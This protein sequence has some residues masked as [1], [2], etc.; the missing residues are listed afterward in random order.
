[1][2]TWYEIFETDDEDIYEVYSVNDETD[3]GEP[4]F[5]GSKI[6]CEEWIHNRGQL[7]IYYNTDD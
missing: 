1:M 5:I 7:N 4:W 3:D 6:D 2:N